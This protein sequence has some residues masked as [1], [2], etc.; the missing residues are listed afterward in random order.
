MLAEAIEEGD[1]RALTYLGLAHLDGIGV[2]ADR[3]K[4]RA[5]IERAAAAGDDLAA[6]TLSKM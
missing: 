3:A 5:L 4:A 6:E 1:A 2:P